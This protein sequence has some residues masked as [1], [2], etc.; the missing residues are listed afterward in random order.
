MKRLC[1][2]K[3]MIFLSFFFIMLFAMASYFS[4]IEK[5][6]SKSK[7]IL[8]WT[9]FF[10][11]KDYISPLKNLHCEHQDCV[12]T[13]DRN[14]L[15]NS[16][17]IIFHLRDM[18]LKDLPHFRLS[19]QRWIMLHHESPLHTPNFLSSLEGFFN[20]SVTY[21]R[22][23]DI[24]LSPLVTPLKKPALKERQDF[25]KGK[26]LLA[27]WFSS[28]C[29][30]PSNREVYVRELQQVVPVDVYGSCG[31]KECLPKMSKKCYNEASQ[32]Y[33]FYLAFENSMCKDYITE[34]FFN[35]LSTDMV[36][37]VLGG[38]D[39]TQFAPPNSFI[40]VLDFPSPKH[41]GKYLQNVARNVTLYNK[42]FE[43]K[44]Y[45]KLE[46]SHYACDIC[47]KLHDHNEVEKVYHNINHWWFV[48][49][50]CKSWTSG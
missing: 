45:Y 20:W 46:S 2:H 23:S 41:L 47:K 39:Y 8:L 15:K 33:F 22:D 48:E 3:G 4:K 49:A 37:V 25:H 24:F 36:P 19:N 27:V 40:N 9:S 18:D 43:W 32:K 1:N 44:Q 6:S 50:N 42:F 21:R 5:K 12:I 13:S 28:N 16:D 31:N 26:S 17:A 38:A 14:A 29:I 11:I 7:I 30:T 35:I 10:G 34:K